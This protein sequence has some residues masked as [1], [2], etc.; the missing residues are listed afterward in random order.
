[1]KK[2]NGMVGVTYSKQNEINKKRRVYSN[3]QKV[4]ENLII[5]E[6]NNDDGTGFSVSFAAGIK[7]DYKDKKG[8]S[9]KVLTPQEIADEE[10]KAKKEIT[11]AP[12]LK[13]GGNV[14][15]YC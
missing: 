12:S 4:S 8:F 14:N 3:Y 9:L 6:Q 2:T 15:I 5:D 13:T 1:M 11:K 7:L 10:N